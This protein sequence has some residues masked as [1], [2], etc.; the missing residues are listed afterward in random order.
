M[1]LA[2][3]REPVLPPHVLVQEANIPDVNLNLSTFRSGLGN[4]FLPQW[5][6]RRALYS[7]SLPPGLTAQP[8]LPGC[9]CPRAG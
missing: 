3:H 7:Q 4:L 1:Y 6:Q 9:P 2:S 5:P 8:L